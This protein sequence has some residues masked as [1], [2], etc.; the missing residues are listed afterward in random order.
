MRYTKKRIRHAK[1]SN[2]DAKRPAS[3]L[4][5]NVMAKYPRLLNLDE[6]TKAKLVQYLDNE[7]LNHRAERTSFLQDIMDMQDIYWAKPSEAK[8]TFPFD[9]ACNLIIPL[10]A[11]AIEKVHSSTMTTLYGT[12][13]VISTKAKVPE[14]V[15]IEREFEIWFDDELQNKIG[16]YDFSNDTHLENCKFGNCIGKSGYSKIT[17]KAIREDANGEESEI[18][19]IIKDTATMEPI[20]LSRFLMPFAYIDP[21][22]SPWVGEEKTSTPVELYD[23]ESSGL[24]EKGSYKKMEAWINQLS[25]ATNAGRIVEQNQQDL[26]NK[27][28]QWPKVVDWNEI[29][30][31]F[32]I[33]K[34]PDGEKKE[35]VVYYHQESRQILAVRYNW[36]EDLHRPYRIGKYFPIEHRWTGVGI[37]KQNDEFQKE[38]TIQHR[39]R[40][41][42]ATL[43][44][45]RMF[46][47]NRLSGYGPGEPIFPGKMWFLDEMDHIEPIEFGDVYTSAFNN[48]QTTLMYSQQRT[49]VNDM[50]LGMQQAGTPGT[51]TSDMAKLQ[52]SKGKSDFYLRNYKKF[53]NQ[54]IIDVACNIHQFGPRNLEIQDARPGLAGIKQFFNLPEKYIRDALIFEIKTIGQSDNKMVDRQSWMQIAQMLQQY[55]DAQIALADQLGDPML[56][57]QIITQGLAASTEAMR[58]VLESFEVRNINR[59]IVTSELPTPLGEKPAQPN[60][61]LLQLMGAQQNG[62]QQPTSGPPAIGNAGGGNQTP[63]GAGY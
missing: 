14:W 17:R 10:S 21:Q 53:L 20:A 60:Q 58:Q 52:E 41:D 38:I 24:F 13:Q 19:V 34:D 2:S 48:E 25:Y 23:L 61:I 18:E 49:G 9:G 40:I 46:K 47:V 1:D 42:N 15:D 32:N 4:V 8:K 5:L 11:I 7:L 63:Q 56:M 16:I 28:P 3:Y 45:T 12:P 51:A 39:Q 50:S 54:I 59:I 62:Q 44:N 36:Y 43:A 29:W 22:T 27:K 55:Y 30:L 33:D 6:D 57:K 37:C 31:C 35:I 26:E